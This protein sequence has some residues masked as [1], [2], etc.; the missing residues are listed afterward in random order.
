MLC[1]DGGLWQ[2]PPPMKAA[3]L[4]LMLAA[5]TLTGCKSPCRQL[6]EKL[7]DCAGNSTDKNSCLAL[8]SS[9]EGANPPN[10]VDNAYCSTLLP[11]CDCRL[12]DTTPGRV[13]CGLAYPLDGGTVSGK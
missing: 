3:L 8:A 7:C 2:G 9:K 5:L 6:S 11:Q 12:I 10:D 4:C 1:S 13:R